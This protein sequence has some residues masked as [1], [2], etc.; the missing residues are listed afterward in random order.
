MS[1]IGLMPIKVPPGVA[2]EMKDQEVRVKGPKG[3]LKRTINPS[4]SVSLK[5][6]QLEVSRP[7]DEKQY[8]SL[9]GLTRTLVANMVQGVTTGFEKK[10]DVVGV[11][12]RAEK[13]GE[14]LVLKVGFTHS[15][16]VKPKPGVSF[17]VD[18][19]NTGIT[20]SGIDKEI[21]GQTAAEIRRVRPPDH[22]KGKGLRYS[23]E[24]IKLKAG[25]SGKAVG[26]KSK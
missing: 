16:T 25:K 23:G 19:K 8:K 20:V 14:N 7:S 26:G 1:R 11:G 22:Y 6:G 5:N 18:A 3:E 10:L 13:E 2:V 4:I 17:S 24:T 12:F 9:H 15:V 21:V